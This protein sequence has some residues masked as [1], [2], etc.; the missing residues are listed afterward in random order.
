MTQTHC[1][2]DLAVF[3][4]FL[5]PVGRRDVPQGHIQALQALQQERAAAFLLC[6]QVSRAQTLPATHQV[7]LDSQ[8]VLLL[9]GSQHPGL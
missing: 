3:E 9:L 5:C 8:R 1:Q 2:T 7:E 6:W 4:H